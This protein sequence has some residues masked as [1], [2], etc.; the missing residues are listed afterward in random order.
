MCT[1]N[2]FEAFFKLHCFHIAKAAK[3]SSF[4]TQFHLPAS[5]PSRST[6]AFERVAGM[7]HFFPSRR[8]GNEG[9]DNLCLL[10]A[11]M[12]ACWRRRGGREET[13]PGCI[14][15]D[16]KDGEKA[17]R[18]VF[19]RSA[20]LWL[21]AYLWRTWYG[22]QE[23]EADR[24]RG[25]EGLVT[26]SRTSKNRL[27]LLPAALLLSLGECGGREELQEADWRN[28]FWFFSDICPDDTSLLTSTPHQPRDMHA[29]TPTS[30]QWQRES[31][32]LQAWPS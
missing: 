10:H 19:H 21:D 4:I 7:H 9:C 12:A 6:L 18:W 32:K 16:E 17:E 11:P 5:R 13:E 31:Y 24:V 22:C 30:T 23:R 3:S 20:R 26:S 8:A 29:S 14:N 27:P 25:R 28:F 15:G 2:W 1:L